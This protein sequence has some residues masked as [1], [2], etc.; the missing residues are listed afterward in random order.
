MAANNGAEQFSAFAALTGFDEIIK[1]H[2]RITENRREMAEDAAAELSE[3]M[4][5]VQ[6]GSVIKLVFYGKDTYKTVEGTVDNIDFIYRFL[7]IGG[8]KIVFDDVADIEIK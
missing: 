1:E 4:S 5:R 2:E 8:K 7:K 6:K 3:K